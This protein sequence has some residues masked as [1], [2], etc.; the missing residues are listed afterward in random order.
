MNI[1][2][3]VLRDV[4]VEVLAVYVLVVVGDVS[5]VVVGGKLVDVESVFTVLGDFSTQSSSLL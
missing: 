3:V 2:M 5:V 1:R 4:V